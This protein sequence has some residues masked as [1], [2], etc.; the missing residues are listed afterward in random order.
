MLT[1]GRGR[2]ACVGQQLAQLETLVAV[3]QLT[4]RFPR[5][6]LACA[7]EDIEWKPVMIMNAPLALPVLI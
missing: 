4:K 7:P 2:H 3:R 5:A 1:F 6:R